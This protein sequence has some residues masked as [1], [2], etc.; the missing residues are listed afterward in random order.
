M[1]DRK[2]GAASGRPAQRLS[3]FAMTFGES[4]IFTARTSGA[5]PYK[6]GA[7]NCKLTI[8]DLPVMMHPKELI[9]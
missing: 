6:V 5:R 9:L 1:F 8:P 2:V 7:R 4:V 3:V